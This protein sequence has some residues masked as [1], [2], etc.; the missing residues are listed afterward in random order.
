MLKQKKREDNY[1][2]GLMFFFKEKE[3]KNISPS[4]RQQLDTVVRHIFF[5]ST[6]F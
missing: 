3:K 4:L 6:F 2:A 1:T 5:R